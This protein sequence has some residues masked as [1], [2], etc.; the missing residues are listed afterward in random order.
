MASNPMFEI[1]DPPI[2][3]K[4]TTSSERKVIKFEWEIANFANIVDQYLKSGQCL[5]SHKFDLTLQSGKT[6]WN[7]KGN[8]C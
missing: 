3:L 6:S 4:C 8:C 5:Q 2:S 7:L 1:N